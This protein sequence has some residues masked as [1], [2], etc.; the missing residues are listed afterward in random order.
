[1]T[2]RV[3]GGPGCPA[4]TALWPAGDSVSLYPVFRARSRSGSFSQLALDVRTGQQFDFA[5]N[6]QA[7]TL[8][9]ED[10]RL[11]GQQCLDIIGGQTA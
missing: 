9:A 2:C 1:M 8:V 6:L 3:L 11:N 10:Q 7:K 5:R 4:R